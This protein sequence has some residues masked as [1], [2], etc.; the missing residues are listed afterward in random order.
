M[1]FQFKLNTP[2][3]SQAEID[4]GLVR[5][6]LAE[7]G[8]ALANAAGLLGGNSAVGRVVTLLEA[9]SA[10]RRLTRAHYRQLR[11]LHDLLSLQHVGDPD[12]I[13]SALFAEF[14]PWSP[15]I[16]EICLLTDALEDLLRQVG[17]PEVPLRVEALI[18]KKGVA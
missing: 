1:T 12:R 7:H 13:E 16:E 14:D 9:L 5:E 3:L 2:Q 17:E 18:K 8:E 15:E 11:A 10:S 4:L 6:F